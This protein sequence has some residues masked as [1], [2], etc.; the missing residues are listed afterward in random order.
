[1]PVGQAGVRRQ[2]SR[3][4][5]KRLRIETANLECGMYVA[6]LDRPWLETPFLLQGFEI[7]NDQDL[8][9]LRHYCNHVYVDATRGSLPKDKVLDARRKEEHYAKA[10]AAP[11]TRLQHA[12]APG[13][14]RRL[15]DAVTRL[16]R[17]GT[18]A[19]LIKGRHYRNV[20]PTR[21]E[22]PR[23]AQAYDQAAA[24]LAT[25]VD[26]MN[27]GGGLDAVQ[28]RQAVAPLVD[29]IL[30]NQDAM[31]WLVTLRKRDL[32]AS[33]RSIG[34]AVWA[35]ILGRH[36]GFERAALD[37]LALGGM[38]LDI[39]NTKIPR[40]ML[41][42]AGPLDDVERSIVRK[43]VAAGIKL[44]RGTPGLNTD[45]IAMIQHHHE[46]HDGSGYPKG[47]KGDDVPVFGRIAG[48]VDCFDAM[49]T[50]RPYAQ[51]RSA[52]DAIRELNSLAGTAFQKELVEQFVQALGMFPTGSLVELN[53][54]EVAV[55]V[56]QNH[57][58]RLRPRLMLL[59]DAG[60][61][62]LG[63]HASLDLRAR[64]ATDGD[65]E[66]CWIQHGLEPG[67]YG[68]DPKDYFG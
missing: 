48:L 34:S 26:K 27:E 60:K 9:Q 18:I 22:A 56:E 24:I 29:S 59:L 36:L 39:G 40:D 5:L 49:T 54:G 37:T 33:H 47:L 13:V 20:V 38:L 61:R 68:L 51:A 16:D 4:L 1:M 6:Q 10:L 55:V 8:R 58:R 28:L 7:R 3:V 63:R 50:K 52:Y 35:A 44:V 25:S 66:G 46:R 19:S 2:G 42:K 64:P 30:R 65:D 23:A 62:P 41:M 67:A 32:T 43:H 15:F 53:T 45:A 31:A 21:H 57:V 14:A 12:R 17:T 11:A